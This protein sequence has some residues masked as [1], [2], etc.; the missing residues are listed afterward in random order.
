MGLWIGSLVGEDDEVRGVEVMGEKVEKM[1]E[2]MR[3][4]ED[5][6]MEK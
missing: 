1:K 4:I 6:Y 5:E 2:G 3:G